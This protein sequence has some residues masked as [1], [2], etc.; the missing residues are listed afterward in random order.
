[1][2]LGNFRTVDV[3]DTLEAQDGLELFFTEEEA[4]DKV[5]AAKRDGHKVVI[6]G[7]TVMRAVATAVSTNGMI[8]PME[9][10]TSKFIFTPMTST[11][12]DAMVSNFHLPCS[13]QLMMVA[14]F[15]GYDL[16]MNAYNVAKQ[17]RDTVSALTATPCSYFRK[18][19]EFVPLQRM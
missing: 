4:A 3:E 1:M 6:I 14:A 17:G 13:T 5:N 16:V 18:K 11:V 9:G 10:W 8:K 15:G 7:T 2:G 19:K 12:G